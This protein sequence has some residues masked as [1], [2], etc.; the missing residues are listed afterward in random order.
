[1]D[2]ETAGR[3]A[4]DAIL[5]NSP[6]LAV[7][8]KYRDQEATG[9][10]AMVTKQTEPGELGQ[11]GTII[12]RVRVRSDQIDEP[13]RGAHITVD[14][15]QVYLMECRTSGGLRVLECSDTQPIEGV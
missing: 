11:A 10:R 1:V 14:K 9:M 15:M 8:V 3:M 7:A 2:I 12:S 6:S 4:F 5:A 13:E